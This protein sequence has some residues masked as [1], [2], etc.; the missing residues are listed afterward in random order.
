MVLGVDMAHMGRRYGD[1]FEAAAGRGE[2]EEVTRRDHSRIERMEQ[3][4]A[5]GFWE[6][7]RENHD[8]LE[9]VRSLSHLRVFTCAAGRPRGSLLHYQQWNIDP[10][11]GQFR[12]NAIPLSGTPSPRIE[13]GIVDSDS[14]GPPARRAASVTA[15]RYFAVSGHKHGPLQILAEL[16]GDDAAIAASGCGVAAPILDERPMAD[17]SQSGRAIGQ[18]AA[19]DEMIV[20]VDQDADCVFQFPALQRTCSAQR[21]ESST[22]YPIAKW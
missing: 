2:M 19:H 6:Q 8:D 3:G 13:P 7:V 16:S 5:A 4:D 10:Q 9:M 17:Q 18:R 14:R 12:R 11:R 1:S 21:R 20:A 22:G 15:R